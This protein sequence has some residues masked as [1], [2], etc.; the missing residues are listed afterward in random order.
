MYFSEHGVPHFHAIYGQYEAAIGIDPII[1]LDGRLPKRVQSLV[2]E[3]ATIYQNELRE[4]WILAR[5]GDPLTGI[6]PLE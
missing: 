2:F 5:V 6:P 4:N 1:I 3:W